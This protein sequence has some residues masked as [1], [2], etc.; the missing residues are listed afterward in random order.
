M[1]KLF[2]HRNN[3]GKSK[4]LVVLLERD[5][6]DWWTISSVIEEDNKFVKNNSYYYHHND[7]CDCQMST[8]PRL[9]DVGWLEEYISCCGAK[10]LV[11]ENN[12]QSNVLQLV[13]RMVSETFNN[14]EGTD[15]DEYFEIDSCTVIR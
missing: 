4:T 3:I 2:N 9:C 11:P 1:Q 14:Y 15:Y 8:V 13:G 5:D 10:S 6:D 7:N 12:A